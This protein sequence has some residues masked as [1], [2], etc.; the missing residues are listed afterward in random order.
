MHISFTCY[1]EL[2][3]RNQGQGTLRPQDL[4]LYPPAPG[5]GPPGKAGHGPGAGNRPDAPDDV[6]LRGL[7]R[8]PGGDAPQ[9]PADVGAV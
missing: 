8:G 7:L 5:G 2:F 6:P 3:C 4:R 9:R 1:N